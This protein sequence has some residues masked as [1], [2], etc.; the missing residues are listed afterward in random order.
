MPDIVVIGLDQENLEILKDLP[1]EDYRFHGLFEPEQLLAR[2]HLDFPG[3]LDEAERWLDAFPGRV[4]AI[5]GYWD[6]PVTSLVP[7][8]CA[9]RGLPSAPLESAAK[10]EHKYW[11]RLE[12]QKV[13]DEHP[14]FG[15]I[16]D[17]A[18]RQDRL[19]EGLD[20]PVWMK[21]VKSAS[22]ELAFHVTNQREL[23]EAMEQMRGG[24]AKMGDPFQFVLDQLDLPDEIA[25]VG[26]SAVLVEESV[27]GA[28]VTVEGYEYDGEIQVYGIVDSLLYPDS[29]S[30]LRYQYP[31]QLPAKVQDR[32][33]ENARKVIGQLGLTSST[34]NIEYF[35]DAERDRLDLLEVNPRHSQS[36]AWLLEHVDGVSNHD[37][38]VRLGLGQQ[39]RFPHGGGPYEVAAKCFVRHFRDGVVTAAPSPEQV[40]RIER[41][42]EGVHVQVAVSEGDRL[43]DLPQQDSYSYELAEVFVAASDVPDLEK[44]YDRCVDLLALDID[45]TSGR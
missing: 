29:P 10:C 37:N 26:G 36:H 19:P 42:I 6:F 27:S 25:S 31:S 28:Q 18:A 15:V 32:I 8:L 38:M 7:M 16:A 45:E 35:W 30:F 3:L 24:I 41:D 33:S 12:Q 17:P 11:S 13:I 21:P 44:K 1:N 14:A 4:D 20:F 5:V 39:P 9:R 2:E 43:H 40:E 22:S 34:F 23:E